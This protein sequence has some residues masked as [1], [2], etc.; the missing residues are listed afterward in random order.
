MSI[1]KF[2]LK[3]F[4]VRRVPGWWEVMQYYSLKCWV[5]WP[6]V[7]L[8]ATQVLVVY[9]A[10]TFSNLRLD[11]TCYICLLENNMEFKHHLPKVINNYWN[12]NSPYIFCPNQFVMNMYLASVTF[13]L[14]H[15]YIHCKSELRMVVTGLKCLYQ[16]WKKHHE[17]WIW[18]SCISS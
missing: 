14:L 8:M 4:N 15:Y 17:A 10:S 7:T 13:L 6:N 12:D 9:P 3:S 16:I 5:F 18:A 1:F 11:I 2:C